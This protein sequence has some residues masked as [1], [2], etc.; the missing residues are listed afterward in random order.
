M[1]SFIRSIV[2]LESPDQGPSMNQVHPLAERSCCFKL[3]SQ[4]AYGRGRS[5]IEALG[6][7][8]RVRVSLLQL[9]IGPSKKD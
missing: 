1:S 4:A 3:R 9:A 5:R 8:S 2:V 6:S 7:D